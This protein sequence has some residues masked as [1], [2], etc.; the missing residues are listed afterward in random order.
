M[1]MFIFVNFFVSIV[2]LWLQLTDE[3]VLFDIFIYFN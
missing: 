1:F 2:N 3:W